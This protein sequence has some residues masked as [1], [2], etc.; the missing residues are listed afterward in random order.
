MKIV[1]MIA[2]CMT[3]NKSAIPSQNW[4]QMKVPVF[5]LDVPSQSSTEEEFFQEYSM[6]LKRLSFKISLIE[7]IELDPVL[8]S[9]DIVGFSETVIVELKT[10][11]DGVIK[12]DMA[13]LEETFVSTY[14]C[15]NME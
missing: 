14:N 2:S 12:N 9:G 11:D 7:V 3:R 13:V 8:Y 10:C 6:A 1:M 15:L 5:P 4:L